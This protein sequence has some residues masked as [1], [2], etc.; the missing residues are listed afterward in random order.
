MTAQ[1][2][3]LAAVVTRL[4]RVERQ[5]RRMR[6]G[7]IMVLLVASVGLLMGQAMPK[8]TTVEAEAFVVR[9]ST[10][11]QRVAL[12]LAPDG[13][14]ALSFFDPAGMGR[15]TL[16][17]DRE[18]SPD[19]T[20]LDQAA[21]NRAVLRVERSGAPRLILFD[22]AG[23][24]RA[25]LYYVVADGTGILQLSNQDEKVYTQRP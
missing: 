7:G 1:T 16:R 2:P 4:E 18:G 6:V 15:A 20:L 13:G 9:D 5:N 22:P 21:Q 10:G 25:S 19:L 17:V 14:A 8:A 23:T 11:K 3:D 24:P 12:H